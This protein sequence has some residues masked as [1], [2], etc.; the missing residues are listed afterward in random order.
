MRITVHSAERVR[1][2]MQVAPSFLPTALTQNR[3]FV[4]GFFLGLGLGLCATWLAIFGG[5]V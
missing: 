4:I 5:I 2:P 3:G 1:F